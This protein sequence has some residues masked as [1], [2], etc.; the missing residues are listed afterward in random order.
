MDEIQIADS[1]AQHLPGADATATMARVLLFV[2]D[3]VNCSPEERKNH[4][5]SSLCQDEYAFFPTRYPVHRDCQIMTLD[6]VLDAA[7][8][9]IGAHHPCRRSS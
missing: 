9:L 8:D 7:C 1:S 5:F 4:Y 6:I 3:W 2:S